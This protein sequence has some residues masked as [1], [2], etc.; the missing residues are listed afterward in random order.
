MAA[1]AQGEP[2]LVRQWQSQFGRFLY[3]GFYYQLNKDESAAAILTAQTLSLALR[4]L[5]D[6]SP[7]QSTM[8]LWLKTLA[9]RQLQESL[10]QWGIKPQRPWAWAEIPA[11]FLDALKRL[12]NDPLP[13]MITENAAVMEIVQAT[14]AEL[15]E[16]DRDLLVR[17]Y[18]RLDTVERIAAE[19][20]IPL[21][22]VN[23]QLYLARHAFR[24]TLFCLIQSVCTEFNEPMVTGGTEMLEANLELLLRSITPVAAISSDNAEQIKRAVLQTAAE[25]AQQRPAVEPRSNRRWLIPA[26]AAVAVLLV[27]AGL[28]RMMRSSPHTEPTEPPAP[29]AQPFGP[30][31]PAEPQAAAIDEKELR[32]A[33]E[34]GVRGD[35]PELIKILKTGQYVSQMTAAH[36]LAQ[37]GG[38]SAIDPLLDAQ[39]RWFPE[40]TTNNPFGQAVTEI[41]NRLGLAAVPVPPAAPTPPP[42]PAPEK[43]QPAL[44]GVVSDYDGSPLSGVGVAALPELTSGTTATAVS[45][46]E[47]R[48]R[49]ESLAEGL[50]VV[51]L[52][53]PKRRIAET[54]RLVAVTK[55][56]PLQ[57]DFGGQTSVAG[58]ITIDAA[59]LA[60]QVILL[61]DQFQNP[62]KGVFTAQSETDERGA[63]LISGVPAGLYGLFARVV[64]NR[65]TLLGQTQVGDD[66]VLL[67]LPLTT[68]TLSVNTAAP[69]STVSVVAVSLR[70]TP[71][72]DDA[73]AQWPGV[74]TQTDGVFE[75][76]G[77]VPGVYTLCVDYSSRVR[78][79][80]PVTVDRPGPQDI[81]I[82]RP[83]T[84]NASLFGRFLLPHA[85]P[86]TLTCEEPPLRISVEDDNYRIDNLPPGVYTLGQTLK[87][88]FAA[89]VEV[90][91]F[92]N[93]PLPLDID[94]QALTKTRVPLY[95]Y[96]LDAAGY[97]LSNGQVWL[98][99]DNGMFIAQPCDRGLLAIVPPGR[100]TLHAVF[101]AHTPHQQDI[102]LTASPLTAPPSTDT[103][104][105]IHLK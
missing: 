38:E 41:E 96:V 85:E 24:R 88:Q 43:K 74:K 17:R 61:S 103:A 22:K 52:K 76:R 45:D 3:T 6:F 54:S 94:P 79:F 26:V 48:Y 97:G 72:S 30:V 87:G 4:Q 84:G 9:A 101:E 66:D 90:G 59:P 80:R 42:A 2:E 34:V 64:A 95:I 60:G 71:D 93:Q 37:F 1:L 32:H 35:V 7:D 55:D 83:P 82:D 51:S 70:Y 63:F 25:I 21:D 86:M 29:A 65:W 27:A 89:F 39:Q 15:S 78:M 13:A 75:I 5:T 62:P 50:W 33:M 58:S 98:A 69:D 12:R 67:T 68:A 92:E 20:D 57:L 105:L 81:L 77:V 11:D 31:A 36:Y 100:Y 56:Q 14:L 99:G 49:I 8:F 18:T 53:D 102:S 73:L 91:L 19:L 40:G 23:N 44:S 10:A 46:A 16:Q 104:I 47:G 28:W